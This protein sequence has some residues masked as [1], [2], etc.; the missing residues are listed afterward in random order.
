MPDPVFPHQS[1]PAEVPSPPGTT[2]IS[3]VPWA[4]ET[5]RH[6]RTSLPTAGLTHEPEGFRGL[7]DIPAGRSEGTAGPG[8]EQPPS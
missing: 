5:I 8:V 2:V 3:T 7:P 1:G 4:T 6:G